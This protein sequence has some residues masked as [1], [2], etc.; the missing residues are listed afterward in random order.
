MYP[1]LSLQREISQL[2]SRLPAL[3]DHVAKP[4]PRNSHPPCTD[5]RFSETHPP[6]PSFMQLA[7]LQQ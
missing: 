5:K 6:L 7:F 4:T 2:P 1:S 3:A